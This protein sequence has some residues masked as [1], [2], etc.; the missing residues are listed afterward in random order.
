[1]NSFENMQAL[2]H[3]MITHIGKH[4]DVA[5]DPVLGADWDW[6]AAE[7]WRAYPG[8]FNEFTINQSIDFLMQAAES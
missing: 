5:L 6:V 4:K 7:T 2:A 1:M 8:I 3:W